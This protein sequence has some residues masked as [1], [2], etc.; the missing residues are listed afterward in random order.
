[1]VPQETFRIS[2]VLEA[3]TVLS[4]EGNEFVRTSS[5]KEAISFAR[6]LKAPIKR[7]KRDQL[8][9]KQVFA[10]FVVPGRIKPPA[11]PEEVFD[12]RPW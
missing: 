9:P 4:N 5:V 10:Q 6:G 7:P 11:I 2:N 8:A 1:V 12:P 3:S